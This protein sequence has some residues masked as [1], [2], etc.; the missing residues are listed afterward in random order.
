MTATCG[1]ATRSRGERRRA[2]ALDS[3]NAE[4]WDQLAMALEEAGSRDSA[5]AAWHRAVALDPGDLPAMAF[6]AIHYWWWRA[7]DSAA[8]WAD[9]TVV[10][11]PLYGLGRV[12]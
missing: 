5:G 1:V 3:L 2:L 10:L 12:V 11:D 8:R 4:A 6:L 7:Y 9:S